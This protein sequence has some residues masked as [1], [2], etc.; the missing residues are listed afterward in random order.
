[1]KIL[2]PGDY[3]FADAA[4]L[5]KTLNRLHAEKPITVLITVGLPPD[6]PVRWLSA[7]ELPAAWSLL[8]ENP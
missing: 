1:M 8:D 3:D 4:F 7:D 5:D 2:V 6:G